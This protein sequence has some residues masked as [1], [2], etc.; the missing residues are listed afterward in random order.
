MTRRGIVLFAALGLIWGIPYLFIKIAVAELSPEM[1]VLARCAIAAV[2]LLP[3][4]VHRRALLPVLRRWKPLLM[5]TLA[6]IVLAWYFLNAAEQR[7]PSSTAG[8]LL[9]AVPLAAV[10]VAFALGRRDRISPVNAVGIVVGMAGVAAIVGLDLGGSDL[11]GVAQ[12]VVVVIGYAV[13]PAVLARWMSDLPGVGVMAA[14]LTISA[15]L[16][17][18]LVLFTGGW[19]TAVPSVPVIVSVLV[20]AVF[21]SALAFLI[22]F[23]LIAE[24]GPIRMTAITYVNP[25]VA[26]LAG[27]LVLGEQ[28]TVWTVVGFALILLGCW[29]VTKPDRPEAHPDPSRK[30]DPSIREPVAQENRDDDVLSG[31]PRHGRGQD[32]ADPA[33]AR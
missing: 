13:G 10:G 9:S 3:I 2:L 18:P 7:L 6:E 21:R 23:A 20:L 29:L 25:A 12:L 17:V 33:A 1:L 15:V 8:L 5:F 22:M 32:R 27:A 11:V 19:P 16:C 31:L 28:V 14:A 30:L 24:I 4:A 26:V